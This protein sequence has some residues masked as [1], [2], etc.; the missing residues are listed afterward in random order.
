METGPIQGW[1]ALFFLSRPFET[2][3]FAIEIKVF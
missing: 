3:S 1:K 2:S